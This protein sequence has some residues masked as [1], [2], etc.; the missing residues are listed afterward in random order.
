MAQLPADDIPLFRPIPEPV[1]LID[2]EPG[3]C[4][5]LQAANKRVARTPVPGAAGVQVGAYSFFVLQPRYLPWRCLF[6]VDLPN[7]PPSSC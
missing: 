4:P 5:P 3:I 7:R 6:L 2:D 1:S